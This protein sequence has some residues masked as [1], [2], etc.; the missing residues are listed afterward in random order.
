MITFICFLY[1]Y[2]DYYECRSHIKNT[3][4]VFIYFIEMT[5]NVYFINI[6]H[7]YF[8]I[9]KINKKLKIYCLVIN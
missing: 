4:F 3:E 2:S 6:K 5:K 7:L 9:L 8:I 1:I